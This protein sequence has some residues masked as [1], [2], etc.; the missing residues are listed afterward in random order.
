MRELFLPVL[1]GRETHDFLKEPGEIARILEPELKCYLLYLQGGTGKQVARFPNLQ[2]VKVVH[3]GHAC[4]FFENAA[5][6]KS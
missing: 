5:E 2:M 3:G 6:M 1:F 4:G